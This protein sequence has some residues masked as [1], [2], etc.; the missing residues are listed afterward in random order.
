LGFT[1]A[2]PFG[3]RIGQSVRT[4]PSDRQNQAYYEGGGSQNEGSNGQHP[5][6][7]CGD[8][9]TDFSTESSPPAKLHSQHPNDGPDG[10]QDQRNDRLIARQR[11][12]SPES[13][14]D[15][16]GYGE[17]R[18]APCKFGALP[19]EARVP[20]TAF[21]LRVPGVQGLDRLYFEPMRA[22]TTAMTATNPIPM[23]STS[24]IGERGNGKPRRI[25]CSLALQ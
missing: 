16:N 9:T 25:A 22:R 3:Y 10:D 7:R 2:P 17:T 18:S 13:H 23:E 24:G 6:R 11:P 15:G 21:V 19:S 12:E 8:R 14:S 5:K 20:R 1:V 4:A